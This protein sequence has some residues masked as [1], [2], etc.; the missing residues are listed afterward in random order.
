[1]VC[2]SHHDSHPV[3]AAAFARMS[4]SLG[5]GCYPTLASAEPGQQEVP[6]EE[7]LQNLDAQPALETSALLATTATSPL[8]LPEATTDMDSKAQ[9]DPP[10][11]PVLQEQPVG[12]EKAGTDA[13]DRS[14]L[15]SFAHWFV[16]MSLSGCALHAM[17]VGLS[18]SEVCFRQWGT[19]MHARF[20]R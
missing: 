4:T 11:Q 8:V 19:R 10:I 15:M 18:C 9:H 2:C 20:G 17:C 3:Y 6:Q 13:A 5:C 12:Q 14:V 7:Q 16:L 1:M